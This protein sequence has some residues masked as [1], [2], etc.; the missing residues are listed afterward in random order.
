MFEQLYEAIKQ[1]QRIIL[2]RHKNPDGDALG[3]QIGLKHLILENFPEKEVHMVGDPAGRY[4][5]LEDSVME[6][7]PDSLFEGALSILLDTPSKEMASDERYQLAARTAR[8]D[9]HIFCGKIADIE[10]IDSG[11]ESCCGMIAFFAKEMGLR[12]T[13]V[14]A[15]A[16]YTGLVTDSGRFRYDCVNARTF[17]MAA[18]LMTQP[19]DLNAI[20]GD[21][22]TEDF[23]NIRRKAEYIT[24]I[25]FTEHRVAYLYNT[26]EEV[27]QSGTTAFQISRGMVGTMADIRGVDIWVNFTEVP[28]G[29]W[30]ELRSSKYNI[31]PVAVRF[32]GGGHRKASGATLPDKETAMRMLKE[33][34]DMQSAGCQE[35]ETE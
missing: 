6:E 9:H 33:L 11:F 34:D 32:G 10:V 17:A 20:Y 4:A 23:E 25:R 7:L 8:V 5:F 24:K 2:H 22:Y 15:K 28:E 29:V 18:F 14:S 1:Y 21:L 27:A 26:Q 16:I 31:N 12:L 19:L 13:P 35:E 3:S 30:A